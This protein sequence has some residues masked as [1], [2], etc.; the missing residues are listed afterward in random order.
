MVVDAT[1]VLRDL[2][3]EVYEPVYFLQ[4]LESYYI[5][6][7][8][9]WIEK[10]ALSDTEKGFNQVVLYGKDVDMATI[11]SNAKRFPM[12]S[13]RQV[14]IVKEAQEIKDFNTEKA[15]QHLLT[16][17]Q[18]P[19]KSTVLV[20]CYKNKELDGRK[21]ITKK[22]EKN[23]TFVNSKKLY[24]NQVPAWINQYLNEYNAKITVKASVM[25]IE[26]VGTSLT[27]IAN[28]LDKILLNFKEKKGLEIGASH[29]QE[30]VGISKDFNVFELQKAIAYKNVLKVNQI[31][32][33]FQKNPKEHPIIPTLAL[34]YTFFTKVLLVHHSKDKSEKGIAMLLKV[35]AF[36][37]KDYREAVKHYP[38]IKTMDIIHYFREADGKTKGINTGSMSDGDI[39][40]ELV[41]K[42]MH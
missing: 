4:G 10:N 25:L 18:N 1:K 33:Y 30:Y 9:S 23:T 5:D 8:Y 35:N 6:T 13:E 29:V 28:E 36:F 32:L 7:I 27:K 26:A 12:M 24:D 39:L 37:V 38:L 42:I 3:K 16:Y 22:L 21:S 14:V 41:F 17:V 2:R 40:K 11:L 31:I 19:L 20:F 34:L 15:Q